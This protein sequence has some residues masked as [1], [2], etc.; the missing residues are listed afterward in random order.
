MPDR[1]CGV[2]LGLHVRYE[3]SSAASGATGGGIHYR[4]E[5]FS[6]IHRCIA[7]SIDHK[8]LVSRFISEH[9]IAEA[10]LQRRLSIVTRRRDP[11]R[12]IICTA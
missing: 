12:R 8:L 1:R 4:Y 11:I 6:A 7:K 2:H 9:S 5:N 10:R 3:G